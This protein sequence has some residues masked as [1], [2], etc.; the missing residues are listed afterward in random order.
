M[1]TLQLLILATA[2]SS[3][4]ASF[5]EAHPTTSRA[6]RRQ[7]TQHLRIREGVRS[8]QLAPGE[9]ARLRAGQRHVR[10]V[11]RR[12]YSNGVITRHERRHLERAQDLQSRR[13]MR[14]KHNRRSI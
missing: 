9:R 8:G 6:D 2:L 3:V 7:T 11:E 5:A 14:M 4:T 1:K 13:T 10:R 12:A